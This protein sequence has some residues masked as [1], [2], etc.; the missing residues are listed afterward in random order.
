MPFWVF[1]GSAATASRPALVV[2]TRS[3]DKSLAN[4]TATTIDWDVN[5]TDEVSG[6]STST[7]NSRL[8]VPSGYTKVRLTGYVVWASNSNLQ[9]YIFL[10]K[11]GG[12]TAIQAAQIAAINEAPL[13]LVSRW[14]PV[15]AGDYFE[16]QALQNSAGALSLR[17]PAGNWGGQSFFQMELG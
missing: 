11:N 9:R 14:M 8:T 2:V 13:E 12:A 16:L 4:N 15:T 6:H 7:N 17:G 5:E 3:A 10:L 1:P